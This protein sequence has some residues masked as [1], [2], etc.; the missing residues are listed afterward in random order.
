MF[1]RLSENKV[2]ECLLYGNKGG[3]K[4]SQPVRKFAF[5]LMYHSKAA[6]EIVRTT[7]N[8]NLPHPRTLK[9][10]M[11]NSDIDGEPGIREET[12]KRLNNFTND[13]KS[14]GEELICSL[15][16]DE[17]YI[18]KQLYFD[19]NR[20]QYMGYPTYPPSNFIDFEKMDRTDMTNDAINVVE[21]QNCVNEKHVDRKVKKEKTI[22][23]TRALVFLL[24]GLNK[25]F[26]F[27]VAYHF[28]NSLNSKSLSELIKEII[29]KVSEQGII[30]SNL[31]FD[32]APTNFAMCKILGAN[33]NVS[34][35]NFQ[36]YFI[37]PYDGTS[38]VYLIADPS[39]ME[40]LMRNLLGN[41]KVL[42][43]ENE[44]QIEWSLFVN[45][46]K[47]STY[48]NLLT[49]KL[50][51]K[52]TK[53]WARNK[54]NV[55]LV[56]ETFSN[57][58]ASSMKLLRIHKHPM[59]E[60]SEPTEKFVEIMDKTFDI[61]NS[62]NPRHSNEFKRALNA[63]NKN[64]IFKFIEEV[65]PYFQSLKMIQVQDVNGTKVE[66]K[67]HVLDTANKVPVLGFLM[68]LHNL[69]RLY[70]TYVNEDQNVPSTKSMKC[71][72]TYAMSQDHLE[73]FFG[74]IRAKNG[75]NDNPNVIQFQGAYRKLLSNV[76]IKPPES[77]NCMILDSFDTGFDS[78]EISDLPDSDVFVASSVRSCRASIDIMSDPI[79]IRNS[80][81][82]D[83]INTT[84]ESEKL[85]DLQAMEDSEYLVDG[86]TNIS[87]A[88]AAKT[89]E[90]TL[91]ARYIYCH[92]CLDI[93][94][95][96]K[97]LNDSTLEIVSKKNPCVSTYY[98]CKLADQFFSAYKPKNVERANQYDYR[99]LYFKIFQEIE[100]NK[101]YT[102]SNFKDHE[103]HLYHLVKYI[104]KSFIAMKTRQISK[105]ITYNEYQKIM[106]S[107]L[108]KWIHFQGQ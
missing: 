26:H 65:K 6:Y 77:S 1:Q 89:I 71:L 78:F 86:F 63:D 90:D 83:A 30:V 15:I 87:I 73:L 29:V 66:T 76:A 101:I 62:C 21:S 70:A 44:N 19:Q 10:W 20:H 93:F 59:F 12:L 91:N 2:L 3:E 5:A 23:A 69:P 11:Q 108:T 105:E 56:C 47:I 58:V 81:Q 84:D 14:K 54:M 17:M 24:S 98:I 68:N 43:D 49:H 60:K 18:R 42:L 7:F 55:R 51:Q 94:S 88:C 97:K 45:L 102:D 80:E 28:V 95:K 64:E 32:G 99:V 107:K 79:F 74:K 27:P 33:L 9:L 39:H 53:E 67:V 92:C 75:F 8:R 72:R 35:N 106:R 36:P 85:S 40:K 50:T 41:H 25:K 38:I 16:L 52:H 103:E 82:F 61:F 13:L 104:V 4:Y 48:G 46:Q 57:S 100:Y 37:N 96:N 31:T 22:L 34:D